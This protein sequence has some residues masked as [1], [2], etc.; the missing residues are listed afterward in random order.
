MQI[1][2]ARSALIT[3]YEVLRLLEE[4]QQNQKLL[5]AQD[6][7]IEYSESLRTV[8]FELTEYLKQ[9]PVGSQT[10]AQVTNFLEAISQFDL[11]RAEKLQILNLRPKSA[12]EIYLVIEECEERFSEEDLENMIN[13]IMQTLPRDDDYVMDEA[14]GE[15]YEEGEEEE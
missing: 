11:T 2:N 12:V 6:L 4:N 9:T 13:I 3:N 10:P 15:G 8:Q 1:K 14:E 5:Q 7:S